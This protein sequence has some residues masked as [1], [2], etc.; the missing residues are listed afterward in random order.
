MTEGTL[1]EMARKAQVITLIGAGGKTTTLDRLA[2]EMHADGY[3]VVMTTTTK[4]FPM[5]AGEP[6]YNAQEPPPPETQLSFW[7]AG[8][9]KETGKWVGPEKRLVDR[10]IDRDQFSNF[11]NTERGTSPFRCWVIEG[12]GARGKE[13]KCWGEH[14]PQ[15][16]ERT[17]CAVLLLDAGLWGQPVLPENLHHP[18]RCPDLV[19]EK[20]TTSLFWGYLMD[21]PAFTRDNC[22]LDWVVLFNIRGQMKE[23]FLESVATPPAEV[24]LHKPRSLR[25]ALGNVLETRISWLDLW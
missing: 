9:E 11:R 12:D 4:V 20:F 1:W 2:K 24:V 5:K 23:N 8:L 16:P 25:L 15:I 7:Y 14:E 22:Q 3:P 17:E 19:G 6:W 13:L 10:A 18:E 21:S